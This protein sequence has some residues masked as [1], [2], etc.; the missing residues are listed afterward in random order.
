MRLVLADRHGE[1]AAD[2]V[3]EHVVGDVIDIV[4]GAVFF[5][6]VDRGDHAATSAANARLRAAG[7]HA[8][9]ALVA[10]LQHVFEFEILHRTGFG[11]Q[12]EHSVLQLGVQDQ[13]GGVCLG[14]A[15]DDEDLLT[16]IDEG[17]E[18]VLGGGG[19]ADATL[20]VEGDLAERAH[21][22]SFRYDAGFVARQPYLSKG[23]AR[24]FYVLFQLFIEFLGWS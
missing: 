19:F 22:S 18:C 10:N 12:A 11:G 23:R 14:V 16:Q 17:C 15:A 4:I 5:E 1:A 9:D 3:A 6:K 8:F 20:S 13:A 2:H 24:G 7:L 21:G